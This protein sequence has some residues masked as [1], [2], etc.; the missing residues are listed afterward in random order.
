MIN[1]VNIVGSVKLTLLFG[2]KEC[3]TSKVINGS[4]TSEETNPMTVSHRRNGT[5]KSRVIVEKPKNL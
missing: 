1:E 2:P 4:A 5:I 3:S